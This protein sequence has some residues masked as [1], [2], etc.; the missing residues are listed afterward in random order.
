MLGPDDGSN[1]TLTGLPKPFERGL[2]MSDSS[3]DNRK[4]SFLHRSIR[5]NEEPGSTYR[6]AADP[7]SGQSAIKRSAPLEDARER[8]VRHAPP[9]P[10]F[11]LIEKAKKAIADTKRRYRHEQRYSRLMRHTFKAGAEA[12]DHPD[13]IS[14]ATVGT[15]ETY[16]QRGRSLF[17]RYR[18]E[19]AYYLA[20]DDVD[21]L[22]FVIWLQGVRPFW[23]AA[24]WRGHRQAAAAFIRTVPHSNLH[25]AL[26]ALESIAG[27]QSTFLDAAPNEE[28]AASQI[29]Y[30]HFG[31]ILRALRLE[32]RG[33][34]MSW[35]MDW[36]SA[37]VHTGVRPDEWRLV[38]IEQRYD[39]GGEKFWLHVFNSRVDDTRL[40]SSYRTIDL[41]RL[42]LEARRAVERI[43]ERAREWTLD[44]SFVA[45]K[46][47]VS[48]LLSRT[49]DL[50]FPRM[51]LHYTLDSLHHQFIANM[52]VVYGQKHEILSAL[53][54][55]MF[56]D[57]RPS[58]YSNRRRAWDDV[59]EI[60][61]PLA[62]DVSRYGRSLAIYREHRDL[63]GLCERYKS[64]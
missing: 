51:K 10:N 16:Q 5:E 44:G 13:R 63:R 22:D 34:A 21:P 28:L 3:G 61:F 54:G 35:T 20:Q 45:H 49:A 37:G 19:R 7:A 24:T 17:A 39:S 40:A 25:E 52:K 57:D 55:E 30:T 41:S 9:Q 12:V 43:A 47:E 31:K 42:S 64:R 1:R 11:D 48:K 60:P 36:M 62:E 38:D 18:R 46:S 53:I 8:R 6:S 26:A 15:L 58:N 50:L 59:T 4:P 33:E 14:T 2:K 56:I 32:S 23:R 29:D 27:D